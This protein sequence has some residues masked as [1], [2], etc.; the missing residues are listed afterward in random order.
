MGTDTDEPVKLQKHKVIRQA[1]AKRKEFQN[2]ERLSIS[3]HNSHT[4]PVALKFDINTAAG[5]QDFSTTWAN[6][7]P[8][9]VNRRYALTGVPTS[10]SHGPRKNSVDSEIS[11]SVRHVSLESRRNSIDSQVS[12]KIA[13]MKTKVASRSSRG[14]STKTKSRHH[15]RRD[16][17]STNS[18]RYGRK[19]SST[20]VDSQ[21]ITAIQK[22][23]HPHSN[24]SN[25][26]NNTFNQS[27]NKN[28]MKRR[29]GIGDINDLISNSKLLL[30]FLHQG[31]TTS[32]DDDYDNISLKVQDS[33]LDLILRQIERQEMQ[34]IPFN[35]EDDNDDHIHSSRVPGVHIH[36]VNTTDD[37]NIVTHKSNDSKYSNYLDLVEN[38]NLKSSKDSFKNNGRSS[39]N[40]IKSLRSKKASSRQGTLRTSKNSR[41]TN[42]NL[43]R[44]E[45][46]DK[47]KDK[48]VEDHLKNDEFN[49]SS[50]T[51]FC[52]E[53]SP[54]DNPNVQSSYSGISI[55]NSRNSKRSCDV[56]IQTNA[57]EIATQTHPMSSYEFNEKNLKNEENEDLYSENHQLLPKRKDITII[58]NNKRR[59]ETET[60][61]TENEKLKLLLLPS[62]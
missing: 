8:R 20:S 36:E 21:I 10:S 53:L 50:F 9:F 27:A 57:H 30:P 59:A 14:S 23:R 51:S 13:E 33:R 29:T 34:T 25:R 48:E 7:L 4:D 55:T 61:M 46:K 37:E 58:N 43:I 3:F 32:D 40:S 44:Q 17:S 18:R 56:G 11:I 42:K 54:L 12:V 2:Q 49:D 31:L 39:K 1:F 41:N 52:S 45:K 38:T 22:A 5:S 19:E 16:F 15:R 6:N 47:E 35:D 26:T 60:A 24:I 28:N 62:K